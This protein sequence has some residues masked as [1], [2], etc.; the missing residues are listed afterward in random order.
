MI[1]P[2]DM[3]RA[4]PDVQALKARLLKHGGKEINVP[5]EWLD[6]Q[7]SWHAV[8]AEVYNHGHSMDPT[9]VDRRTMEHN[10]CH[11][12]TT[13]LFLKGDVP[14]FATGFALFDTTWYFHSWGLH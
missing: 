11:K 1:P 14:A 9:R 3:L 12:N 10:E 6:N 2:D 13:T 5:D 4:R 8:M 7:A